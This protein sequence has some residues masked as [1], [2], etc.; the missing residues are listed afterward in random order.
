MRFIA[1]ALRDVV[2]DRRNGNDVAVVVADWCSVERNLDDT[3]ILVPA[4]GF[5]PDRAPGPRRCNLAIDIADAI[6]GNY[7]R[8]RLAYDFIGTV[9]VELL[10]AGIPCEHPAVEVD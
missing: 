3:A 1:F 4:P 2:C 10:G 6:F 9:A 7:D 5:E 8:Q